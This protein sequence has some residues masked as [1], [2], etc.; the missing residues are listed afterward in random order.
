MENHKGTKSLKKDWLIK[1]ILIV[2]GAVI[3][4]V[5]MDWTPVRIWLD[6]PIT[7][8]SIEEFVIIVSFIVIL[9]SGWEK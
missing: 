1:V 6:Q 2:T 5:L 8:L 7:K 9:L 4:F 3:G